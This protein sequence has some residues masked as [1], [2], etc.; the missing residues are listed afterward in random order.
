VVS[1]AIALADP[2]VVVIG[3]PW[4]ADAAVLAAVRGARG[5]LARPGMLRPAAVTE[6]AP[7]A[8]ARA[9]AVRELRSAITRYRQTIGRDHP[10]PEAPGA[11]VPG[12]I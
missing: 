1:A 9:Q 8:G 12:K 10:G 6:D 11:E 5:R 3:G 7:L 4:G 2:A